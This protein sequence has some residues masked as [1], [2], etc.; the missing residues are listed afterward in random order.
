MLRL[1]SGIR[2]RAFGYPAG[3]GVGVSALL[4]QSHGFEGVLTLG[5]D[6]EFQDLSVSHLPQ[7]AYV[8]RCRCVARPPSNSHVDKHDQPIT[9]LEEPFRLP[10]KI[11]HLRQGLHKLSDG[12]N[13]AV[14]S[15]IG[16][17]LR[18][19]KLDRRVTHPEKRVE[20]VPVYGF[21]ALP[22]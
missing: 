14:G 3:S 16:S 6:L 4:R 12:I 15:G 5:K 8:C 1:R 10:S 19:L 2:L 17:A 13:A 7:V 20:V 11:P 18:R 22:R 21:V 9:R